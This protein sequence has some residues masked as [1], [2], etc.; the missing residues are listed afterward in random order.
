MEKGRNRDSLMGG[1]KRTNLV[2]DTSMTDS[3]RQDPPTN[4]A[5]RGALN[6]G[7]DPSFDHRKNKVS[8]LRSHFTMITM[9]IFAF[10]FKYNVQTYTSFSITNTNY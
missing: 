5:A 3:Q 2:C 8:R 10:F 9:I 4:N 1:S 7:R 6:L